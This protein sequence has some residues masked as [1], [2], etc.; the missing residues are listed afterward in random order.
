[1]VPVK[2]AESDVVGMNMGSGRD[3]AAGESDDLAILAERSA[4][5]EV[6]EGD[7]VQG[8]DPVANG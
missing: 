1:M 7:F 5:G 3:R 6:D 2:F 8:W 4:V